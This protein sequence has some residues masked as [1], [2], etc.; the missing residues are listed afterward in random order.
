MSGNGQPGSSHLVLFDDIFSACLGVEPCGGFSS[1][2]PEFELRRQ[3]YDLLMLLKIGSQWQLRIQA[4]I[5]QRMQLSR[6]DLFS[7][8]MGDVINAELSW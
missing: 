3:L 6:S 8:Q 7:P 1:S 5:A 4:K 2:H